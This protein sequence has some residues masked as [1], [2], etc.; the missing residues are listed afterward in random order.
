VTASSLHKIS[1]PELPTGWPAEIIYSYW[2]RNRTSV[3]SKSYSNYTNEHQ[4]RSNIYGGPLRP[5]AYVVRTELAKQ[6][7]VTMEHASNFLVLW[8]VCAFP[9]ADGNCRLKLRSILINTVTD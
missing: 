9:I 7:T 5:T 1:P 6:L 3:Y 2:P 8:C 4:Y